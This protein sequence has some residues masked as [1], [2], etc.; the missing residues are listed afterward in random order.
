M[1]DEEVVQSE[2][3]VNNERQHVTYKQL[4]IEYW[5]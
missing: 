5:N 4:L 3:L 1:N 2:Y